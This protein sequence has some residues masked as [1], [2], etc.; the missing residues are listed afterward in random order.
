MPT[1]V[2]GKNILCGKFGV[3]DKGIQRVRIPGINQNY[4]DNSRFLK[5][6]YGAQVEI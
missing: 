4:R 3:T 6:I 5:A 1:L 2:Q